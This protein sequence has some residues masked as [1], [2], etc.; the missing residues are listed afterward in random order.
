MSRI[1]QTLQTQNSK[2]EAQTF[3]WN[4]KKE[5]H[6]FDRRGALNISSSF[7]SLLLISLISSCWNELIFLFK[8]ELRHKV[9][10]GLNG[11]LALHWVI[12][13]GLSCHGDPRLS[14]HQSQHCLPPKWLTGCDGNSWQQSRGWCVFGEG[15]FLFWTLLTRDMKC[16]SVLCRNFRT[17]YD[18]FSWPS[19]PEIN[20]GEQNSLRHD[21][22]GLC[23]LSYESR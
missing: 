11:S 20:T 5:K 23:L 16:W 18:E 15:V 22:T 10:E 7:L 6:I 8:S 9:G 21:N 14:A 3:N 19:T 2:S 4:N 12:S 17:R 13:A 1:E